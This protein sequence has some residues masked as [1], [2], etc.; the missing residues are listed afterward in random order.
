MATS[1]IYQDIAQRT[2]GD[3]YIG[4]VGPVRCGKST[5]IKRFMETMVLPHIENEF[6]YNRAKDEMPQ[7]SGG[8]TV[9]TTE[10]KFIPD[11]AVD[12]TFEND[13]HMR[14]KMVDCVG[15]IVPSA[16]GQT[17]E[18]KARMVNTPW[19]PDP[20][21]FREAAELG[22]R[23]VIHDHATVG[24]VVTTDGSIGE[25]AR[26]DYEEA[27]RRVI[28]EL[29]SIG[30][31]FVIVL[32]VA[33]PQAQSAVD[34]ANELE[35]RYQTPVALVNCLELDSEDISGI[36]ELLLSE[37]PLREL[38]VRLP[39]WICALDEKH[40]LRRQMEAYV[41]E[42]ARSVSKIAQIS[43]AFAPNADA[44]IAR[45]QTEEKDLGN[46][47][48][49][50]SLFPPQDLYYRVLSEATGL[51]IA[52]QADLM[53]LVCRLCT[54]KTDYDKIS[55][56]LEQVRAT[57]YGIVTPTIEELELSEPELVRGAG[58]Y[59]VRLCANAASIHMIRA[60][61]QTEVNPTVGSK[62]Q[63]QE[64][65][66]YLRKEQESDPSRVWEYSIFGRT[67]KELMADGLTHK[68]EHIPPQARQ[69]LSETLERVIN[70]GSGGLICI[71]L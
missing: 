68:M 51:E 11:E 49:T 40:W 9:M 4:V 58:G 2:G 1:S 45:V 38:K 7:S 61:V 20:M 63:T 26:E 50:L 12:V 36:M 70:E 24:V 57:G 53:G 23:K 32:N 22:T 17:E 46:G 3:V 21:P 13:A 64:L 15:Y 71:I 16:L 69:K 33:D 30:K 48:V 6:E 39:K 44:Q 34:L 25:I 31:P 60:N 29:Q 42:E 59:G 10:P 65:V 28:A 41:M 47:N 67:L 35:S 27:E 14:V 56:A 54:V 18:G 52:D 37:F 55:A 19:S 43:D 62:E 66:E 8:K 5:F